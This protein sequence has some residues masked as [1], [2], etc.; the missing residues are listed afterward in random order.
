MIRM[1]QCNTG[2]GGPG[3]AAE[4]AGHSTVTAAADSEPPGHGIHRD[5]VS[6]SPSYRQTV[7]PAIWILARHYIVRLRTMSYVPRTTSYVRRAM[8][9]STSYIRYRTYDVTYDIEHT[10]L[11]VCEHRRCNV[12]HRRSDVRYRTFHE[13]HVVC[14]V[15][16][17][18]KAT[19]SIGL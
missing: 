2:K 1:P 4:P 7:L 12:R 15:V 14:D 11:Y 9:Y 18:R 5:R 10:T 19:T 13:I 6:E 17:S 8:S 3:P 16:C